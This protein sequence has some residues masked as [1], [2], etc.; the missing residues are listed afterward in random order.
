MLEKLSKLCMVLTVI[1]QIVGIIV[2]ILTLI[3][4]N[5]LLS[6]LG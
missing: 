6:M 4:T 5:K 3:N 1:A 2:Q